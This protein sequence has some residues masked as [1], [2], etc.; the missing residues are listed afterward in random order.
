MHLIFLF[1]LMGEL[2]CVGM[3]EGF[4]LILRLFFSLGINW[5]FLHCFFFYFFCGTVHFEF[6]S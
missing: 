6:C 1:I 2:P 3:K 4:V 5:S